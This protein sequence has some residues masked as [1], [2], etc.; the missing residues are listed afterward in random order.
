MIKL[1]KKGFRMNAFFLLWDESSRCYKVS[2]LPTIGLVDLPVTSIYFPFLRLNIF[3]SFDFSLSGSWVLHLFLFLKSKSVSF[4]VLSRCKAFLEWSIY[5]KVLWCSSVR[6]CS[7]WKAD[8]TIILSDYYLGAHICILDTLV[9]FS[10]RNSL[11]RRNFEG[12]Y[13]F[14]ALMQNFIGVHFLVN[15]LSIFCLCC[16]LNCLIIRT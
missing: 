10:Y 3:D 16:W 5:L 7:G 12:L 2:T 8:F 1:C 9:P 6:D 15:V 4:F 13:G 11:R 14:I